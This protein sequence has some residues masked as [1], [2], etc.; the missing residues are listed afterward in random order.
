MC[1]IFDAW[2]RQDVGTYYVNLF[3]NT[4]ANWCGAMP[5][6]CVHA[7][8]CGGNSVIEHNGDLYP[9]DHFV[10]PEYL[11][12]NISRTGIRE[13]MESDRQVR[14]GTDKRN[15]LPARCAR[16]KYLFACNGECPKHRFNRTERG[17]TG[18]NAL[19]EG[20]RMFYAHVDKYMGVMRSLLEQKRPPAE[21]MVMLRL[22]LIK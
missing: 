20:Y 19:C 7:K 9:C 11:L 14:F 2:V 5:G 3:D 16:C 22:G 8:V 6:T 15:T 4:L 18:L 21:I 13:M 17:D 1:D 10:Y 12:G